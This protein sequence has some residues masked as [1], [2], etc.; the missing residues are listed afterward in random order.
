MSRT[1]K[2]ETL[3]SIMGL[4]F[5]QFEF[6]LIDEYL[7]HMESHFKT[8]IENLDKEFDDYYKTIEKGETHYSEE[9]KDHIEGSLQDQAF[10]ISDVYIKNYRNA[11]IIQLYSFMEDILKKGC[12]RYANFKQTDYKVDD[13]KGNNDIDKIKIFLI[14]SAK[15]DFSKLNP[16]WMFIDNVRQVRNIIVHN[17]G[18]IKN[19]DPKGA[20]DKRFKN[21]LKFSKGRFELKPYLSS[22]SKFKIVFDE[23]KFFK[24]IMENFEKLLNKIGS[25][26]IS[27]DTKK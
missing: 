24:E 21:V 16:E 19:N 2:K 12:S 11:Q 13:L 17:N 15:V 27:S 22:E 14:K 6:H 20:G 3:A 5:I 1:R 18:I 26:D 7:N 25:K 4:S 10:M 8:E 9:Y 23:P